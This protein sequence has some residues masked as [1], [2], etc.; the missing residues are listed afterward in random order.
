MPMYHKGI[1]LAMSYKLS[2]GRQHVNKFFR[3]S[4]LIS[5][6]RFAKYHKFM[7]ILVD[8]QSLLKIY[9]MLV[10]TTPFA[11]LIFCSFLEDC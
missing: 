5:R 2:H 6:V 1:A 10:R 8:E 9:S 7:T 3:L 11:V 4:E